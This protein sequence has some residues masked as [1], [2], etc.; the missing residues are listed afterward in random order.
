MREERK[1]GRERERGAAHTMKVR[2]FIKS[3]PETQKGKG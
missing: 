2:T 3:T 1:A